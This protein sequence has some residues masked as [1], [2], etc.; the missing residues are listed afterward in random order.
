MKNRILAAGLLLCGTAAAADGPVTAEKTTEVTTTTQTV[1]TKTVVREKTRWRPFKVCV[2]DFS[3]PDIKGMERFLSLKNQPV[4]IPER[5]SLNAADHQTVSRVMQGFVRMIDARSGAATDRANRELQMDDNRFDRQKALE[6]YHTTV[7]GPARPTVIG[8]EY[9]SAFLSRHSDVFS[10]VPQEVV[11]A[12]MVKIAAEPDFPQDFLLK[13][14][15]ATGATHLICGTVS[16][17]RSKSNS[18]KGYGIETKTVNY[19]LDVIVKMVDLAAQSTVYGNVFT[20]TAREQSP[21]ST[22]QSDHDLFQSMMKSALEQAAG[23]LY[24]A[25]K[26]GRKNRIAVT[27]LPENR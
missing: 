21:V 5:N 12:A 7:K 26:P 22:E 8:A 25:C 18:F 24:D 11:Q 15:R 23:E 17:V 14:A 2:L 20:G 13:L 1:V 6:L 9:L 4:V 3:T 16:D 10:C 19:Q 27:P